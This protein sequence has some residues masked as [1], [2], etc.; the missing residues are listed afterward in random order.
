MQQVLLPSHSWIA[1]FTQALLQLRPELSRAKAVHRAIAQCGT[2][3]HLDPRAVALVSS[4]EARLARGG[5]HRA[6]DRP[7][8]ATR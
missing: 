5:R 1:L 7:A 8:P 6:P 4:K 2:S 3:Q